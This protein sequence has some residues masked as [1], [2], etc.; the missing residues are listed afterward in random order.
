MSMPELPGAAAGPAPNGAAPSKP[1]LRP[2][3]AS[4]F[5]IALAGFGIIGGLLL[6]KG[7]LQDVAQ[8]TAAL[9]V[10]GGTMGAVLVTTP[11]SVV[12]RAFRGL[13]SVFLERQAG[14]DALV[15]T[16]ISY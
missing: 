4:L 10:L 8:G 2:D 13:G 7:R 12:L 6:E 11:M 9:I 5:G 15:E 14:V 16:L 3:W 1:G